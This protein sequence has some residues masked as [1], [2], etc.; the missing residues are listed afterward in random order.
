MSGFHQASRLLVG[1]I[2]ALIVVGSVAAVIPS[3]QSRD[4][5]TAAQTQALRDLVGEVRA[6]RGVIENYTQG[7]ARVQTTTELLAIQQRR[8][9]DATAR[10]DA[11]RRELDAV[12]LEGRDL[13]MRLSTADDEARQAQGNPQLDAKKRQQFDLALQQIKQGLEQQS[14]HEQ[15]L[16][17]RES[18]FVSAA[19]LE[20]AR[21]SE[22]VD[23]VT[24]S[25]R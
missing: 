17:A 7:Q 19:G 9:A 1:V 5:E 22:L 13:A 3:A 23:Q 2:A 8:A 20:E 6:L 14:Q 24:R 25:L 18:E 21:W 16:R 4:T 15:L 12:I 10:L 11:T